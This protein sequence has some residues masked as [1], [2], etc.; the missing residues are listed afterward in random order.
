MNNNSSNSTKI[1]N[2]T[3]FLYSVTCLLINSISFVVTS[4][5]LKGIPKLFSLSGT[6]IVFLISLI[7]SAI[8][9]Y[10]RG[11]IIKLPIINK[12]AILYSIFSSILI[13]LVYFIEDGALWKFQTII[14]VLFY[15]III[16]ILFE[17]LKIKNKLLS[18]F[19]YYLVSIVAFSI[20]TIS[21][22]QYGEGNNKIIL[23]LTFT[24]SFI[25]LSVAHFFIK[26]AFAKYDNEEKTYKKQFE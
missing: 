4:Y 14:L 10:K 7:V 19:I 5:A 11:T 26:K 16:S 6:F 12:I 20:L 22:A 3:C 9:V 17:Y 24:I 25:A 2:L 8:L 23:L 15:S 21:I 1:L 13:I 18:Y